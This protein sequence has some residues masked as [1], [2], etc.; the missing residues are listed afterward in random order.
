M[1]VGET[2]LEIYDNQ[3]NNV[4]SYIVRVDGGW[5]AVSMLDKFLYCF[6]VHDQFFVD[7][8]LENGVLILIDEL[9]DTV[10]KCFTAAFLTIAEVIEEI[11]ENY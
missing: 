4:V 1:K 2:A 3:G 8:A 7:Y 6:E 10:Y 5:F 11:D 9:P